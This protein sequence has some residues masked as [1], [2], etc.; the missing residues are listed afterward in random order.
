MMSSSKKFK[1][2]TAGEYRVDGV[3]ATAGR[4]GVGNFIAH[5]PGSGTAGRRARA[6]NNLWK[7]ASRACPA[8]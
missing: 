7:A 1:A 8:A 4:R 5:K 2:K 3:A 6:P